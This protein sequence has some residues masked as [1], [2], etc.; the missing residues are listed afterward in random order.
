MIQKKNCPKNSP[1]F[2]ESIGPVHILSY[3]LSPWRDVVLWLY[4]Q[5]RPVVTTLH[6]TPPGVTTGKYLKLTHGESLF[7]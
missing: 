2:N 5:S 6:K 7:L 1:M 3:A 4:E